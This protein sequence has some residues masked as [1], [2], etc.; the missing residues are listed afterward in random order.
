M[1]KIVE[2]SDSNKPDSVSC[3][4]RSKRQRTMFIQSNQNN[5]EKIAAIIMLMVIIIAAGEF[6]TGKFRFHFSPHFL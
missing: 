3:C 4:Y 1:R 6:Q 2:T 5:H